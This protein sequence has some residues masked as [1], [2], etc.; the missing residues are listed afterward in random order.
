MPTNKIIKRDD[1]L[2]IGYG[3]GFA[4][5]KVDTTDLVL[6]FNPDGTMRTC[7]DLSSTQ[8][9][10]GDKTFTGTVVMSG[11]V[12]KTEFADGTA[13][14]PS[15]TFSSDLDAGIYRIGAD[16]IGVAVGGA[17]ELNIAAGAFSPGA[18]DGNALG[19]TSLMWSDLFLASGAV[20][21]F[22]NGNVTLTHTAGVLTM[23]GKLAVTSPNA[24]DFSGVVPSTET[25][26][27][28]VTTGSTWVDHSAVGGTAFKL[29]CS[30]SA[31]SGDYAT[32][33]I[34]AR[35]DADSTGGI[36]AGNFSASANI[37]EYGNLYA[38]QGYAQPGANAQTGA[39]NILCGLYSCTDL[40][41]TGSSGR[42]WSLWVDTHAAAKAGAGSYLARFSHNGTVANDGCFTIYNGG[43]MPVLFNFEDAAGFLTDAGSPGTT[44]AGY[45]AVQTP[46]GTKYIS[47]FTA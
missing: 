39:D 44:A 38:V 16:N 45:I 33:R 41:D 13:A 29:L 23:A 12:T 47:L 26:G 8:T 11:A 37:A 18:S 1:D 40:T 14:A 28:L 7:V 30:S 5:I 10:T 2:G 25:N 6:Q 19:T 15:I 35:S 31:A 17:I 32:L 4:G 43:R 36:V 21:N 22:N 27:S 3:P 42:D 46:A 9:I 34:R 20:I 24:I